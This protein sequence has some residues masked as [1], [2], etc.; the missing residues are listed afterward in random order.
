MELQGIPTVTKRHLTAN[1]IAAIASIA[2]QHQYMYKTDLRTRA[3]IHEFPTESDIWK[4][5]NH[6]NNK[7]AK[8]SCFIATQ[9]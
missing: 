1:A 4:K 9:D 6:R 7:P 3:P 5:V 8:T 2:G